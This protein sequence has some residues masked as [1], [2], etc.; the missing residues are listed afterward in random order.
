[1]SDES[2]KPEERQPE[3]SF[4]AE[5]EGGPLEREREFLRER[6][7]QTRS[8]SQAGIAAEMEPTSVPIPL[9]SEPQDEATRNA[10]SELAEHRRQALKDFRQLRVQKLQSRRPEEGAGLLPRDAGSNTARCT[11]VG[12]V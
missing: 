10:W 11:G 6:I 4:E 1:M 8:R 9:E 5:P 2:N 7:T 12:C 3:E